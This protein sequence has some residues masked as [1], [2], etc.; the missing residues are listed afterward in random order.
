MIEGAN[1]LKVLLL[2]AVAMAVIAAV[3]QLTLTRVVGE[4]SE[5]AYSTS[6]TRT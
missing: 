3:S 2:A 5:R 6:S 1:A 4:S